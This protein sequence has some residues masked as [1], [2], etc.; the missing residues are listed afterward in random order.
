MRPSD[1]SP[2][3]WRILLDIYQRMTPDE[4]LQRTL[5]MSDF[6]RSVCESGVRADFPEASEREVFL[7]VTQRTL[8]KELFAKVYGANALPQ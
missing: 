1:T 8:G 3:A 6:L 5:D 2:E 4:K 7:R